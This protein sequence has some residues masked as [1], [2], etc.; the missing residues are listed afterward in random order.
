M[1][2]TQT[3]MYIGELQ[4]LIAQLDNS[5]ED[6][7]EVVKLHDQ[8]IATAERLRQCLLCH[9]KALDLLKAQNMVRHQHLIQQCAEGREN[10]T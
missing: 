5:K 8:L 3:Q 10:M 7:S 6:A 2:G 9:C 4:T 1:E